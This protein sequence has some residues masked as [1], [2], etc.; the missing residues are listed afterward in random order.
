MTEQEQFAALSSS[1][2][3]RIQIVLSMNG[4]LLCTCE[5]A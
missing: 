1:G 4:L 3:S 5:K 2:F